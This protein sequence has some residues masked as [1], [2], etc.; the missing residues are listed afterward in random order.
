MSHCVKIDEIRHSLLFDSER[1]TFIFKGMQRQLK[2]KGNS[3]M[4]VKIRGPL[5]SMSTTCEPIIRSVPEWFGIEEATVQYIRDADT[6][7][8]FIAYHEDIAIGFLTIRLHF[9][10]TAE[11]HCMAI[12]SGYHRKGVGRALQEFVESHLRS[13]G[14]EYLQV[15]TLSSKHPDTNYAKTREFYLA[16]GFR[17]LEEFPELWGA[18]NPCLQL[19]KR[20]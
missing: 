6:L 11:I 12:L 1:R 18:N 9:E 13:L 2:E 10:Y 20:L 7:P 8:T 15:K 17:P 4:T 19:I 3:R 5:Y 14:I 16:M